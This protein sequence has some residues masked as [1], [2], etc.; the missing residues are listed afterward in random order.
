M[1]QPVDSPEGLESVVRLLAESDFERAH[2][3]W[4]RDATLF[5]LQTW[6]PATATAKPAGLLRKPGAEWVRCR[7]VFSHVRSFEIWEEYDVQPTQQS[8]IELDHGKGGL[9]IRLRSTH[10]LRIDLAVGRLEGLL[11]DEPR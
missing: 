4:D 11:E 6:R 1:K 3:R 8:L 10:G 9:T 7:L 2:C 5:T